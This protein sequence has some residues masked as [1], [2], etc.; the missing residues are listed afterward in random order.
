MAMAIWPGFTFLE[1]PSRAAGSRSLVSARSTA[2]SVSGSRPR[3]RAWT[4]RESV[5]ASSI[6]EAPSTTWLLVSTMPSGDRM[7][8]E[9]DPIPWLL[10]RTCTC[11]TDAEIRSTTPTTALE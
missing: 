5:R 7:V 4:L 2:M 9:P 11:T 8:P 1:L 3:T 6:P 10:P